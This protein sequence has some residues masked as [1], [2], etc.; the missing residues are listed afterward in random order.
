MIEPVYIYRATCQRVIDGDTFVANVDLGF[1]VAV[2][3][4]VRLHGFSAPE[5]N[6]PGGPEATSRL[7]EMIDGKPLVLKSFKDQRSFERWIC[8]VWVDGQNLSE[9]LNGTE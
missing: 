7:R 2:A 3:I 8:D 4:H 9:V 1:Y 6:Q 5:R